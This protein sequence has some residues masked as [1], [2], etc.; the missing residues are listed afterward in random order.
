[1]SQ[2]NQYAMFQRSVIVSFP[3]IRVSLQNSKC[4]PKLK[5]FQIQKHHS[6]AQK[7]KGFFFPH[8]DSW[9]IQGQEQWWVGNR[10][11]GLCSLLPDD[12]Q[13]TLTFSNLDFP[14]K[15]WPLSG[16]RCNA[17]AGTQYFYW[18]RFQARTVRQRQSQRKGNGKVRYEQYEQGK[19]KIGIENTELAQK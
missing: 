15:W 4:P 8:Q 13:K 17:N 5:Q 18:G 14:S 12:K 7:K 1:M 16:G 2:E 9:I 10:G 3:K 11:K 6:K 19:G